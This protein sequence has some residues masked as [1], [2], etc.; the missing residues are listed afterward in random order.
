M[1]LNKNF[2]DHYHLLKCKNKVFD[3]IAVSETRITKETSL[4]ININLKNYSIEFTPTDSS[5]GDMLLYIVSHMFYKSRPD[6]NIY[7]ANQLESSFV[8]IINLNKSNIVIGCLYKYPNMD[9]FDLKKT[10]LAKF[11]KSFPKK[12]KRSFFLVL[13]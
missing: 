7:K 2:D 11:L 4:T 10:I 8:E 1:L 3:I 13:K 5:A 9:V 12:E 6:F